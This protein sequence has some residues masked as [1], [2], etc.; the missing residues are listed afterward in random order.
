MTGV[1]MI[2]DTLKEIRFV[3]NVGLLHS[4]YVGIYQQKNNYKYPIF[5]HTCRE[6]EKIREM[7]KI[8][9]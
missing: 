1:T 2:D 5:I 7:E 3:F 8:Y 6:R 9:M 4:P